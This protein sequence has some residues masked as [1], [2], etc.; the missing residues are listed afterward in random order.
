MPS[1]TSRKAG[2]VERIEHIVQRSHGAASHRRGDDPLVP[3]AGSHRS[4]RADSTGS[5]AYLGELRVAKQV[6][7]TRIVATRIDI[8]L[9][10]RA[11]VVT[12]FG[13]NRM[14]AE[15]QS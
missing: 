10:H 5:I 14:K 12:Q 1:R 9:A 7:Q 3:G 8:D 11:W 2:F 4:R 13:K 6:A 15:N